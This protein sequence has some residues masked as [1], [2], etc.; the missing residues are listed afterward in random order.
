MIQNAT[1]L[2][3][4][5]SVGRLSDPRDFAITLSNIYARMDWHWRV[6]GKFL[7]YMLTYCRDLRIYMYYC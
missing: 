5:S 6:R 4:V 1:W 7:L 3:K 2:I